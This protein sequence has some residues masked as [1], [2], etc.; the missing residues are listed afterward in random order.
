VWDGLEA[1]VAYDDPID[2]GTLRASV[3]EALG[4]EPDAAGEVDHDVIGDEWES[5]NGGV[6]IVE[7]LLAQLLA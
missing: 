3:T 2:V 4:L 5:T 6:S 7:R 1:F